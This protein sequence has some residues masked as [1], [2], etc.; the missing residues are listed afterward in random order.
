MKPEWHTGP[1]TTEQ[2][3]DLVDE[4]EQ[5]QQYRSLT[6]EEQAWLESQE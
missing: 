3:Q 2:H 1:W 5:A 6:N 4:L